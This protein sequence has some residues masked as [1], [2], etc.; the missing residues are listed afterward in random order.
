MKS[1][2]ENIIRAGFDPGYGNG[3][4]AVVMGD[5]IKTFILPSLVG[6]TAAERKDGLTMGGIFRGRRGAVPLR[7]AFDGFEYLVG[8]GVEEY[9]TVLMD[10]MDYNRFTDSA[11]LRAMTYAMLH[12]LVGHQSSLERNGHTHNIALA[13]ALPV[14]VVEREADADRVE[15]GIRAWL[16]GKHTFWINNVE[17]SVNVVSVRAKISQPLAAWFEWGLNLAGQWSGDKEAFIKAPAW[18]G[19]LG[20]N[21]FD[22]LL[23]EGGQI[24]DRS[25]GDQLGMRRA[26]ERLG[27][28]LKRK[29]SL[30]LSPRSL[31]GLIRQWLHD[32]KVETWV[33]GR[34][35]DVTAETRQAVSSLLTDVAKFFEQ[36][37]GKARQARI[38]WVG[39]GALALATRMQSAYPHAGVSYEPIT[40]IARGLAK[41]AQRPGWLVS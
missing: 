1:I 36:A 5:R 4:G 23:I 10:R 33:E 27:D 30:Q 41:M 3:K 21:T 25:R 28:I 34:S 9:A 31:D 18:I 40:T 20:Y 37:A 26:G 15:R 7:I 14:E 24:S 13:M 11:E 2:S 8:P 29:Y 17:T 16:L 35:M 39:G 32:G 38:V 12:H 6:L 22:V 19:D